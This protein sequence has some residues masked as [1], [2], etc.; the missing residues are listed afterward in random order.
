[1]SKVISAAI[2]YSTPRV[3]RLT[4]SE[5]V[6]LYCKDRNPFGRVIE[7]SEIALR[8]TNVVSIPIWKLR[9][10]PKNLGSLNVILAANSGKFD[11][12]TAAAL[13]GATIK[14]DI[15]NFTVDDE[16]TDY[17]GE[18]K[19]HEHDGSDVMLKVI[20]LNRETMKVVVELIK[21]RID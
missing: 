13:V 16:Y 5:N 21:A 10:E 20:D 1:M 4:L 2:V 11:N 14:L 15:T 18:T 8:E 12:I 3:I 17:N 9:Q 19:P 6:E 7:D